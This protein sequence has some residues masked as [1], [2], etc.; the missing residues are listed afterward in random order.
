MRKSSLLTGMIMMAL[1]AGTAIVG[2]R[3][4]ADIADLKRNGDRAISTIVDIDQFASH[5][6]SAT[7]PATV[8]PTAQSSNR[9]PRM[10][11]G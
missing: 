1:G 8:P 5:K 7:R 10:A 2:Y 4:V 11:S 3:E 6:A 9:K